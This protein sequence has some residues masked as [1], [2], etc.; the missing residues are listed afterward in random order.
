ML[1][2]SIFGLVACFALNGGQALATDLLDVS[3]ATAGQ[4][5]IHYGVPFGSLQ[6]S[7]PGV[8]HVLE[9]L[10]FAHGGP[11]SL[12]GLKAIQGSATSAS[13]T[14]RYTQYEVSV[15]AE[16]FAEAMQTLAQIAGPLPIT[17]EELAREKQVVSQ[18]LIERQNANPDG[19]FIEGFTRK[20]LESTPYAALPG[21]TL[22]SVAQVTMDD[23]ARFNA[24]HYEHSNGFLTI[25]GPPLSSAL[26][27]AVIAN[28]PNTQRAM[29][30]VDELRHAEVKD[31]GLGAAP[32]FLPPVAG[33]AM[34]P[35]KFRIDGTSSHVNSTRMIAAKLVSTDST[36][37]QRLAAVVVQEIINSR[38]PEG[39]TDM[40][41]EDAGLVQSFQVSIDGSLPHLL[42]LGLTANLAGGVGVEQVK[43]AYDAWLGKLMHDG[44]SAK[45]FERVK[46]RF[47]LH[48][49]WDDA[50]TRLRDLDMTSAEFGFANAIAIRA[51]LQEL[52]LKDANDVLKLFTQDGREGLAVLQPAGANP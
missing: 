29:V 35:E 6:D 19:P 49:E 26:Q 44:I 13:T 50:E 32:V 20:L 30:S 45:T 14:Y 11:H 10:K 27:S 5:E 17:A 36:W 25:A 1:K 40:I 43:A 18:E 42:R 39:L 41:A 37:K 3:I 34:K 31:L 8:A 33:F 23:V 24:A 47:L 15:T 9:H 12:D 16:H 51:N 48:D 4:Y 22:E 28:F 21:G 52:K 38:L 46:A 7:V 2:T